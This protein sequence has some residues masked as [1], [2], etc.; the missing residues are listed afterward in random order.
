MGWNSAIWFSHGIPRCGFITWLAVKDRLSTGTR[1]R[2]WGR[3]QPC[4]LCGE[5]DESR[6]HLF[7][8]C[9][10]TFTVWSDIAGSLL[11]GHLDP[12]WNTTLESLITG[13]ANRNRDIL[14]RLCFQTSIYLLWRERNSRIHGS[15]FSTTSQVVRNIDRLIRNRITS[16]NYVSRPALRN[17]LQLWFRFSSR[18]Q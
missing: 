13:T 18:R 8:A 15:A 14:L 7:F 16:L 5:R 4:V 10:F 6:D 12:D 9:P 11:Q 3:N 2:I 17:L 1:M